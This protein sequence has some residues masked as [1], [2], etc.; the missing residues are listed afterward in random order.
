MA[1]VFESGEYLTRQKCGVLGRFAS[2]GKEAE[3]WEEN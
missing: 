2:S 3:G 1:T